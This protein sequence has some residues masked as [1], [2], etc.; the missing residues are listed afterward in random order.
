MTQQQNA[1]RR[2]GSAIFIIGI[3]FAIA[4]LPA[5]HSIIKVFLQIAYW[6][7]HTVPADL[8]VPIPLLVA[9]SGGLTVGLGGMLWSLG[10]YVV[11]I[12]P[13]AAT[14]VAQIAAW[15]WF[16]TDS[17][18]SILVGAPFNVVLNLSFL[19]LMLLSSRTR[20]EVEAA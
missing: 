8:I 12:S 19:T 1:M 16:C 18:A 15:S 11:P 7:F 17:T 5:L 9:I 2:A 3:F 6:P 20:L 14:K 4:A 13:V 10:T